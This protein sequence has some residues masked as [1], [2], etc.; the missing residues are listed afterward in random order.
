MLSLDFR[1]GKDRRE[2]TFWPQYGNARESGDSNNREWF[3]GT[4]A[5]VATDQWMV[6]IGL[7]MNG[8]PVAHDLAIVVC[9]SQGPPH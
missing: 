2:I 8:K 9:P 1:V 7:T 6:V 5:T 4:I 3:Q